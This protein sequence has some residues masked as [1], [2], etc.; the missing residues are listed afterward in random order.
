MCVCY[1]WFSAQ[2]TYVV[3]WY[4]PLYICLGNLWHKVSLFQGFVS[5]FFVAL[6]YMSQRHISSNQSVSCF[7]LHIVNDHKS[8]STFYCSLF[9][10]TYC[11]CFMPFTFI[12]V[13]MFSALWFVKVFL[14]WN[15]QLFHLNEYFKVWRK[16]AKKKERMLWA[17]IIIAPDIPRG[18]NTVTV[19][20]LEGAV[21]FLRLA[22]SSVYFK[23]A[24]VTFAR[25]CA[26]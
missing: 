1:C 3:H 23:R 12:F 13:F 18:G 8:T 25:S 11:P 14:F 15:L 5:I 21:V 7:V 9:F 19:V 16:E 20:V 10:Y 22:R 24:A 6:V 2:S 26:Q 4:Q 17:I